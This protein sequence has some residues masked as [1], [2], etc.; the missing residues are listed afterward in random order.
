MKF[1][2]TFRDDVRLFNEA[3]RHFIIVLKVIMFVNRL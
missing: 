3:F 2:S 1:A